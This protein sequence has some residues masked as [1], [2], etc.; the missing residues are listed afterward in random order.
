[1]N[2]A[3][4]VNAIEA[5]GAKLRFHGEK[6]LVS[7]TDEKQREEL[8]AYIAYLRD[9]RSEVEVFLRFRCGSVEILPGMRIL[10]WNPKVGPIFVEPFIRVTD[11][12]M[13]AWSA[14]GELRERLTNPKR[15]YGRSIKQLIDHLAKVGVIVELDSQIQK[16]SF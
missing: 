10:I 5:A 13:F 4:T 11:S 1:M 14:V 9:H 15:K 3:E 16:E 12:V 6:M 2:I 8:A 7:Y